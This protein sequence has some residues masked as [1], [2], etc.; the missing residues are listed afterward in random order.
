VPLPG[1]TA[2]QSL[3]PA[4]RRYTANRYRG[5]AGGGGSLYAQQDSQCCMAQ[6]SGACVCQGGIGKCIP[7]A[8]RDLAPSRGILSASE[9]PSRQ[10]VYAAADVC[11]SGDGLMGC[12]CS[13]GCVA[14]P[15]SCDCLMCT[16][17]PTTSA[18]TV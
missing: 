15:T 11:Q 13:C 1:F 8:E 17:P 16:L 12:A 7:F 6:C 18:R 3:T 2:E 5:Y 10:L 14:G 9:R 4:V